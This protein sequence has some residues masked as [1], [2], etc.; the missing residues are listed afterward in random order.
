MFCLS[1]FFFSRLGRW[2]RVVGVDA[3]VWDIVRD[4]TP[5]R[6]SIIQQRAMIDAAKKGGKIILTRDKKLL[7]RGEIEVILILFYFIIFLKMPPQE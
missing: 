7:M 1:F 5:S 3:E 2:L 6:S 4:S